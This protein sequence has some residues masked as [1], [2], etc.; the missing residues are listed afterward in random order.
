[1]VSEPTARRVPLSHSPV[2]LVDDADFQRV[3][4]AGPWQYGQCGAKV[5]AQRA[6]R[7]PDGT[8]KVE[9]LHTFL[10]GWPLVDHIDGN[11]LN[12]RRS[13]LRPATASQNNA[14]SRARLGLSGYRGVAL[15]KPTGL[16]RAYVQVGG[17]TKSCG[18]FRDVIEAAK[19]RDKAARE[20]HGE[21]ARL[22][23]PEENAA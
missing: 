22:N 23:F 1:M 5:Y 12:N 15:H 9:R 10:T 8:T 4:D 6:V 17:K 7:Q 16:W 18:Y 19:A 11:G 13:N 21:F 14:N 2:T 3:T 20:A